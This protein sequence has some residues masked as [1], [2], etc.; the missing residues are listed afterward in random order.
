V[1]ALLLLAQPFVGGQDDAKAPK[2]DGI[3]LG[4]LRIKEMELRIAFTLQTKDGL[5]IAT[6]DSIDQAARGL[7]VSEV[8][9][10]DGTVRLAEKK[11]GLVY[12]GKFNKDGTEIVGEW[13]QG[14]VRLPPTLK[15]VD[16]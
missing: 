7:P 16:N 15:R 14:A 12:E 1:L 6:L 9:V 11:Y 3:W 2:V 4:A 5:L 8:S 13:K 10:K